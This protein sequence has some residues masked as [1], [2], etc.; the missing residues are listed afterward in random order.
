MVSLLIW[1]GIMWVCFGVGAG[2]IKRLRASP[3]S[4]AE[5]MPLAVAL[6][7]GL[8]AYL[9]LAIGLL[10][11]LRAWLALAVIGLLAALGWRDMLM[12]PRRLGALLAT[13]TTWRW[14]ALLPVLFF[15]AAGLLTLIGALAPAADSDYDGLV[16]HLTIPKVYLR[17][18]A[19]H[20]IPWLSHSN[21]PFTLEMLYLLGLLL[22]DET[23]AKLFHFGCGWLTV[24]AVFAFGRRWWSA[25]AGWL[26]AAIFAAIPLVGWQMMSSY[27]ELAFALCAFLVMC[28][29]ARWLEG[30]ATG[31]AMGW[32]WLAAIMCG[33]ALGVKILAAVVLLFA[34]A[35]LGWA[36]CR[37]AERR[38]RACQ[39]L[40]FVAIAA[41]VASPWYIKSYLWTGNPVYP[42][43]YGVFDGRYWSA[44]R[45]RLYTEAQQ[46]FGLGRGPLAFL[47]LP[48]NLT[49]RPRW[50][51]DQPQAL[52]FFN[53]FVMVFGPL[54]LAL[55]PTLLLTG[56]IGGPGRLAL[57]FALLYTAIWFG[58]TQNGRYLIPML[59]GLAVCAGL[60]A[61]RLLER[62]ATASAVAAAL[63]LG[64][65]S[66]LYPSFALAA[67][68]ARV[69]LGL[70]RRSA[71]LARTSRLYPMFQAINRAAPPDA[72]IFV[73]GEEPRCFYLDR[74]FLLG[75]HAELFSAQDLAGPEA[76]LRALRHMGVTHLLLH[77]STVRDMRARS[78]A[79]ETLLADL[80][81]AGSIRPQGVYG[82]F[83]LWQLAD[84]RSEGLG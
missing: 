83:M 39:I 31:K 20:R 54:L 51:F 5:E 11:L 36:M 70:E 29:V 84:T 12:L 69:A 40:A 49:M 13:R 2:A 82:S 37:S 50:F 46:A 9:M 64:L 38:R 59:P 56:P 30:R 14:H 81:A 80:D 53:V 28:A 72:R 10:G 3:S 73:L 34:V 77:S 32:L 21:F 48:W 44:E 8:L 19:I 67:P 42:F 75:N 15:L 79:V 22:R 66:G 23:L 71:Y 76:F 45:A 55:L 17:E 33:L 16:Y 63:V 57:W 18:G 47:A 24:C 7:M 43:L 62:R 58:L 41:A 35:A 61:S 68:A 26:G 52:R 74:D 4:M 6:G 60:A 1:L 25:R 27:N 65:V 78:G